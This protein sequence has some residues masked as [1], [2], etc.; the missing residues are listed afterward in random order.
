MGLHDI[1][2]IAG[3][4]A[5]LLAYYLLQAEKTR[6]NDYTYLVLNGAGGLLILV[7]LLYEFNL[8][9]FII[10]CAW[11]AISLY[12]LIKRMFWSNTPV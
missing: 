10:E 6:F 12:G 11:I 8:S 9:A 5:V 4:A 1:V 3:V 2:G 7:S